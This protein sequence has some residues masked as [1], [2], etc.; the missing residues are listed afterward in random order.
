MKRFVAV[1]LLGMV[2]AAV[3]SVAQA[4]WAYTNTSVHLRAGPAPDYPVVAIL[5]PSYQVM[6]HGCV[7]DYSWCDVSVGWDRG[8]VYA[9]YIYYPY[10][11]R[12][13][14]I[15]RY[16]PQIG[17]TI[18]GF[19][20]YD[21]WTDHYRDRLFYRERDRWR[22]RPPLPPPPHEAPRMQRPPPPQYRAPGTAPPAPPQGIPRPPHSPPP[23]GSAPQGRRP[24]QHEPPGM[25]R[26]RPPQQ[27][28]PGMD[29][30]E[31]PQRSNPEGHRRAPR[32]GGPER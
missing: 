3:A 27:P 23:Q 25:Q 21:Y 6:V 30:R 29:R 14:P 18:L 31:P 1:C 17:L 24:P 13:V 4:Q 12:D 10:R 16:G 26:P 2:L 8:W 19:I 22:R 28:A 7:A 32:D 15:I 11:G 5:P 20:L 9:A